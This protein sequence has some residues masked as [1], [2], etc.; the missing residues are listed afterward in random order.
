[1]LSESD[2][3]N[4]LSGLQ[5][6]QN[7]I[8]NAAQNTAQKSTAK[9]QQYDSSQSTTRDDMST[10]VEP[11]KKI[12]NFIKER[13]PQHPSSELDCT[14]SHQVYKRQPSPGCSPAKK[15]LKEEDSKILETAATL[16]DKISK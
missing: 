13:T 12:A 6:L 4:L 3:H 5:Q 2:V 8:K 10:I 16:A 15:R 11:I 7:T 9:P 1:M 14:F